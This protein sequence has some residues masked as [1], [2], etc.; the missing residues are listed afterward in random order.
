[1]LARHRAEASVGWGPWGLSHT[2]LHLSACCRLVYF[3]LTSHWCKPWAAWP[4]VVVPQEHQQ[5]RVGWE[6]AAETAYEPCFTV[7][8]ASSCGSAT[9]LAGGR[10]RSVW[11]RERLPASAPPGAFHCGWVF[12]CQWKMGLDQGQCVALV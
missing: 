7:P 10:G 5:A 1:M 4:S 8:E 12:C 11:H 6:E 9:A 2:H 3:L